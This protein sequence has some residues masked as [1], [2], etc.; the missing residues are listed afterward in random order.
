M[1]NFGL[2]YLFPE[3][4]VYIDAGYDSNSFLHFSLKCVVVFFP[5]LAFFMTF[6]L[7]NYVWMH[8]NVPVQKEKYF[9]AL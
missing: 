6:F 8:Y 7:M 9:I 1:D 2:S 3:K 5:F 4:S